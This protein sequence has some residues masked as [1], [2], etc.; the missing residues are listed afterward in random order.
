LLLVDAGQ[1]G[2]ISEGT[3][4]L[5]NAGLGLGLGINSNGKLIEKKRRIFLF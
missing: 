5:D 3:S 1:E 4:Y 2:L